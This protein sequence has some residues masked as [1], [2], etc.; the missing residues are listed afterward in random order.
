LVPACIET[1]LY[2]LESDEDLGQE[3]IGVLCDIAESE[4]KFFKEHF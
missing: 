3:A 4:P 1:I 2:L